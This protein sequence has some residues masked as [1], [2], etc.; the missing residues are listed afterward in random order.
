[1]ISEG[2]LISNIRAVIFKGISLMAGIK[3]VMCKSGD[4]TQRCVYVT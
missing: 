4:V 2:V 1:M 3:S